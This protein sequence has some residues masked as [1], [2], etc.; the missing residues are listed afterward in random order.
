MAR[1]RRRKKHEDENPQSEEISDIEE[2]VT[3]A[4][5]IDDST[6]EKNLDS[7]K[8]SDDDSIESEGDSLDLMSD[9]ER[10]EALKAS[11]DMVV[12]TC[13]EIY[14]HENVL[15]VADPTTSE[16]GEALYLSA[17][18]IS[19]RVL[20]VVMPRGKHHGEE[21]PRPVG[22]LMRQ[23]DVILAPTRYSLTHTHARL[24]ATRQKARITTMPG[25]NVEMFTEGG[26]TA[27]FAL[28]K[29]NIAEVYGR[30]RRKRTIHVTSPS[31]TDVTFDV[32]W[33]EWNLDDS[34]ICN[35]PAMVTNLPAG[36]VFITPKEGS[37]DGTVVIDGA[38]DADLLDE[39]MSLTI[40]K[41]RVV[42]VTGGQEAAQLRQNF[43]D[44]AAK[45]KNREREAIW[46][47]AEFGFGMNPKARLR[48]NILEDEK[49]LGTSYFTIGAQISSSARFVGVIKDVTIMIDGEELSVIIDEN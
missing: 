37:M 17:S 19:D 23:Q 35:R 7:E 46:E 12:K 20:M 32:N 6:P 10:S 31:G 48:G 14:R 18:E 30:L 22:D 44:A 8:N 4:V 45:M 49:V 11:A 42:D 25:M 2:V 9:K 40:E 21:P 5:G 3:Q 33:R 41:G 47:E 24:A 16:I 28:I 34:G 27:D 26:M 29:A 36:K 15:I 39:T 1:R 13:M 38:W 43:R